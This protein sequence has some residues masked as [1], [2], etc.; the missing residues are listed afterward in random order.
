[1]KQVHSTELF[2]KLCAAAVISTLPLSAWAAVPEFARQGKA[3]IEADETDRII[4]KYKDVRMAAKGG[5]LA[6]P[7]SASRQA[8]L[9]R[10]GQQFGLSMRALHA[11]ATGANVVHIGKKMRV[12]EVAALARDLQERD[13][14]V[15]YAEPDLIQYPLMTPTDPRYAEQWHYGTGTGGLRATAAWDSATGSGVVVAVIDTGYRAHPDLSGNILPG[16]DFISDAA[17]AGDGGGRD[18]DATDPGDW[19]TAEQCGAGKPA[20]NSSWHGTHVAGTVAARTNNGVGVAGVA[21]N[22]KVVPV[23]VLGK[24]GGYTSDI[25]D[26]IIWASGGSVANVPTNANPA[27]VINLSLGGP[28]SCGTAY[29]DAITSA[30]SRGVVVV[31]AAGNDNTEAANFRPANCVGSFTVA[32]TDKTGGRAWYSNF[33]SIVDVA[34]PGGDTSVNANGILSTHNGGTQGPGADTYSFSQGTSMAA[35]H[36]AGVAALMISKTPAMTNDQV[37]AKLKSSARAFPVSCTGCGVGIVDAGAAVGTVIVDQKVETES[38]NT[39]ATANAVTVS[40]TVMNGTMGTNTDTDY[41]SV[42]LPAGKTLS[43]VLTP[44]SSTAD[45]DLIVYN[46]A[47]TKIGSSENGAGA[48][49]TVTVTNTGTSTFARYV[50][51]VYYGGGSGATSGKYTL[52]LSW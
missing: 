29:Q 41:F 50:R 35:P 22:A 43:S 42:Q 6:S 31:V 44:G 39:T 9:N 49:D 2:M 28:G 40:G 26:G 11:T 10:S 38:N 48:V 8:I 51:V 25:A 45:Y 36:V 5:L 24:C 1:M 32:A 4:V 30:R 46:S 34:A 13:P 7:M 21:F 18:S 12:A 33:G 16:Y 37:E 47:G 17:R 19:V 14:N 20:R 15:L 52:K 3:A 23:R 27:K